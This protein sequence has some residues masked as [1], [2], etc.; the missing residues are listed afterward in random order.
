MKGEYHMSKKKNSFLIA[1]GAALGAAAVGVSYYLKYKSFNKEL[2]Q[3]FHEYEDDEAAKEE[4]AEE[5]TVPCSEA[6]GRS[7]ITI[8]PGKQ[9]EAA[10]EEAGEEVKDNVPEEAAEEESVSEE[11][12][13]E[14]TKKAAPQETPKDTATVEEDVIAGDAD[15]PQ[16]KSS[17]ASEE[18]GVG[19]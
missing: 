16:E 19:E 2:D 10:K 11:T 18:N 6:S 8:T 5:E 7:Y 12:K 17:E 4:E 13:A 1:F 15:A 3:D 14:E 9:E